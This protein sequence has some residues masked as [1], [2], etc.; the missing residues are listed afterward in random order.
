MKKVL[1]VSYNFPPVGGA[2]VQRPVKFVKYLRAFG[3]DPVVLTVANASVPVKDSSLE[4]DIPQG[5]C[6]CRSKTLEPCYAAKQ[7]FKDRG[8][9][10][11]I[12]LKKTMKWLF[13][14]LML[15]D[16]QVLW[17]PGLI[18]T[19]ITTITKERPS[20]LF[21]TA[22]PFSSFVP[23]V[24]LGRI[25][26]I[27]VVLDYRD[28]WTFSRNTWE[29]ASKGWLPSLVDRLLERFVVSQCAAFTAANKSYVA[30]LIKTYPRAAAGKGY[31]IT[32][33]F[34]DEDFKRLKTPR[35]PVRDYT[36]IIFLYTGTV[37][38]ATSFQPIVT[39]LK[40]LLRVR[41]ELAERIT[42]RII[43]RVIDAEA[44]CFEGEPVGAMVKLCG[45]LDHEK[46]VDE[47]GA[48]DVL[49][50]TLSDLPGAEKIITGKVFEYMAAGKHVLAIV[51]EGETKALLLENYDNCTIVNPG[52]VELIVA[53]ILSIIENIVDLRI[54]KVG[55]VSRFSRRNLTKE[56]ASV[57]NSVDKKREL[58]VVK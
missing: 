2:G 36:K 21:V 31:V 40:D 51:P 32:N 10:R 46:V 45:Y 43:G 9:G 44:R 55:D 20:C 41:P 15:P 58:R 26:S 33:G 18:R 53:E 6:V 30:S 47:L 42:L 27:P 49:L 19:L 8:E 14:H 5:V 50:L 25:F 3:W 11:N 17:W 34:D 48:A 13:S 7:R 23:V 22:P 12:P 4:K 57:F 56:L 54:E 28:E 16:L 1:I 39:A 24:V 52:D 37:W 29:N 38:A 35:M